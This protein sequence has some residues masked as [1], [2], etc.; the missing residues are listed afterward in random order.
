MEMIKFIPAASGQPVITTERH[1]GRIGGADAAQS[2]KVVTSETVTTKQGA[3]VPDVQ[4]TRHGYYESYMAGTEP[5]PNFGLERWQAS[6]TGEWTLTLRGYVANASSPGV[7]ETLAVTPWLDGPDTTGAFV[8]DAAAEAFFTGL[9]A[10]ATGDSPQIAGCQIT[11]TLDASELSVYPALPWSTREI[12]SIN[13]VVTG[14]TYEINRL[15]LDNYYAL[16][17]GG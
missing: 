7:T 3:T 15:Y 12:G 1:Y 9:A 13:G 8:S 11:R 16:A 2:I 10:Q 6:T 17:D 5:D 4:T 14:M